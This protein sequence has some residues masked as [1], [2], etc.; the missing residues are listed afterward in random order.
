[1]SLGCTRFFNVGGW[2]GSTN[3]KQRLLF[4][5]SVIVIDCLSTVCGNVMIHKY[6]L[7]TQIYLLL[8][9]TTILLTTLLLIILVRLR[10]V[11]LLHG[12]LLSYA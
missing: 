10:T 1:M 5:H 6:S 7:L 11:I 4:C 2:E 3:V 8:C 12:C 9:S